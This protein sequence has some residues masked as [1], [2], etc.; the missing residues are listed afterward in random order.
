[1]AW[2]AWSAASTVWWLWTYINISD[3]WQWTSESSSSSKWTTLF[4][5]ATPVLPPWIV[6][7]RVLVL[8]IEVYQQFFSSTSTRASTIMDISKN[9]F[10]PWCNSMKVPL[11]CKKIAQ[12]CFWIKTTKDTKNTKWYENMLYFNFVFFVSF[13]VK[14]KTFYETVKVLV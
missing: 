4:C 12:R 13:V 1:M 14:K 3:I 6:L 7:V 9:I 5:D 2:T 10:D 8:A 11:R